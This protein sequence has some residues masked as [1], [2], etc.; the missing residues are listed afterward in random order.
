MSYFTSNT[1]T[2]KREIL[3]F[4]KKI[5]SGLGNTATKFNADMTYGILA[6]GSTLLTDI[7]DVLHEKAKK[8]NTVDRLSRHLMAGIPK[9]SAKSL[10]VETRK[11]LPEAPIVHVDDTD[12]I[13]PYGKEFESLS[14]VRDGSRSTPDKS[15][16]GAGYLVTEACA[17]T[18]NGSPVSVF[19]HVHSPAEE[20]YVSANDITFAAFE[21][22]ERLFKHATFVMDR[23][24]DDNKIF[25]RLDGGGQSFVVRL[26]RKRKLFYHGRWV[27]ADELAKRR[28]G[29]I[30]M[31]TTYHGCNATAYVSHV[32]VM[33]TASRKPV[34]LVLVYGLSDS[35]MMLV[36]NIAVRSKDDV[37]R[38]ARLYFSRWRIEEYFRAKK[39]MFGFENFR[40]RSLKAIR[41]MN[42][43]LTA[44]MTFLAKISMK[45]VTNKLKSEI[46]RMAAPIKAK[47]RFEYYRISKGIAGILSYA[48]SGVGG[49]FKAVRP[50]YRQLSFKLIS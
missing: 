27:K 7:A 11:L 6:S 20:A 32:S 25:Q 48:H 42:F 13:K 36:S 31:D 39:Q 34:S 23:G 4:S 19:S 49:F 47:V 15:V 45:K 9:G 28:K 8:I 26:T 14:R 46:I 3:D 2:L 50:Q 35:P 21:R 33:V 22:A 40:V 37:I 17:M 10:L 44:C 24:Y 41:A 43:Y 5:S 1:Y 18:A 29:K 16:Y 30:R 38:I 12:I